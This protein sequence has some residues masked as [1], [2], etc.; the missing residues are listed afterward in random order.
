[1]LHGAITTGIE[2]GR[3]GLQKIN[4]E[5]VMTAA[6]RK[7]VMMQIIGSRAEIGRLSIRQR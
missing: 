4:V 6:F 5:I 1:M 2:A 3:I 7:A